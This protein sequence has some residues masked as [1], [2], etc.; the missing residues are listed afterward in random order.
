MLA[1]QHWRRLRELLGPAD[2]APAFLAGG[3][4]RVERERLLS[5]LAD[6][7]VPVVVGTHA[8][9]EEDVRFA[10]LGLVV[11][12]EQHRFGVAQRASLRE[13]GSHPDMLVMTATPIPRTLALTLYG[14]L[15][16]TLID[17]LPPGR[18]QVVT[19]VV[20]LAQRERA[21]AW[22]HERVAGG[23]RA[24]IVCPLIEESEEKQAKA[25]ARLHQELQVGWPDVPVGLL[26]GRL[27]TAAREEAMGAFRD[28]RLRAL[29]ATTVIEVGIDVPEATVMLI[30]GADRFGLAQLHQLRG[31]VG[32]G[33]DQSY[34]LLV[35][36]P[37][38]AEG[39]AR[40][41]AIASARDGFALAEED[42]RLRGPGEFFGTR[43]HGLPDLH[44]ADLVRDR[45]LLDLAR[46]AAE[47][48]VAA[49]P[50]LARAE[51]GPLRAEVDRAFAGRPGAGT[52]G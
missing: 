16:L 34:C 50:S 52:I 22:L 2:L 41:R 12:D 5:G 42:L 8:L 17:E 13:K 15:D 7:S 44:A 3:T 11:V 26:H 46:S 40:L 19:R 32:R 25:A 47:A 49:D 45:G 31:R 14:D 48:V 10:R 38:T 28:G 18:R 33:A 36:D 29:V 21:Y 20:P 30:E 39:Q 51:H 24:F 35:A 1:E 23:G 6:G 37:R 43:Q 27:S 4:P 9:L